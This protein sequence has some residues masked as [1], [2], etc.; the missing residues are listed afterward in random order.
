MSPIYIPLSEPNISIMDLFRFIFKLSF[1]L[2][3]YFEF[4]IFF[5]KHI[6][7]FKN[8]KTSIFN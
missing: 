6:I 4:Y 2:T 1:L 3:F 5:H 8:K 7:Q